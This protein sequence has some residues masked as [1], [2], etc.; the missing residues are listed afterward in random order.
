MIS[1]SSSTDAYSSTSPIDEDGCD[2]GMEMPWRVLKLGD[3]KIDDATNR[4]RYQ[5][6]VSNGEMLR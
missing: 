5:A 6:M 3:R 4:S 2:D 1:A